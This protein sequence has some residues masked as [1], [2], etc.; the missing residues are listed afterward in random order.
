M[1]NEQL[2]N[3]PLTT[4]DEQAASIATAEESF[5]IEVNERDKKKKTKLFIIGGVILVLIATFG[6]VFNYNQREKEYG[7][8]L[9]LI[10]NEMIFSAALAEKMCNSYQKVW[11]DTIWNKMDMSKMASDIGV[12]E[13]E[14]KNKTGEY[15]LYT[16]DF[17]ESLKILYKYYDKNGNVDLLKNTKET[18]YKDIK[19]L[20]APPEKYKQ[21]Y[22][23]IMDL[24]SDYDQYI[25][26]AINPT[27]SLQSYSNE[28]RD[29]N[30]KIS[31]K[32]KEFGLRF[33]DN[34]K[35]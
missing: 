21:S 17:N 14:L 19:S 29:L 13:S 30:T 24:Y 35:Q 4:N 8:K 32:Y 3:L 25:N 18:V 31:K 2:D 12:P 11:H 22:N 33:P 28:T 5:D 15:F 1:G 6:I 16:S 10:S 27:G 7:Q 9:D 34:K 26:L 23:A 20:D